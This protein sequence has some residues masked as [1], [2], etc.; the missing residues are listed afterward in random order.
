MLASL[1]K[2]IVVKFRMI[3]AQQRYFVISYCVKK[4]VN[5]DLHS[6]IYNI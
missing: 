3:I 6:D 4:D 1:M 5:V 2:L